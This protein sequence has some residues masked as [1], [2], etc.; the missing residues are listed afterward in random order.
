MRFEDSPDIRDLLEEVELATPP[1]V[2]EMAWRCPAYRTILAQPVDMLQARCAGLLASGQMELATR[3]AESRLL[4]VEHLDH[5]LMWA[6]A[7]T[8]TAGADFANGEYAIEL[9]TFVFANATTAAILNLAGHIHNGEASAGHVCSEC[10]RMS[11][12]IFRFYGFP[13]HDA[14]VA[15]LLQSLHIVDMGGYCEC[16]ADEEV[17]AAAAAAAPAH[18]AATAGPAAAP[19]AAHPAAGA[20]TAH[21]AAVVPHRAAPAAAAAAAGSAAAAQ[22]GAGVAAAP[23]PYAAAKTAAPAAAA[24]AAATDDAAACSSLLLLAR[25]AL[26]DARV[27]THTM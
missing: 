12:T 17:A 3:V 16:P 5:L 2:L 22:G 6:I 11:K 24:V 13:L 21:P 19:L 9:R 18:A 14:R 27:S 15:F 26:D 20:A 8:G 23:P 7:F 1:H 10:R 25:I 4:K